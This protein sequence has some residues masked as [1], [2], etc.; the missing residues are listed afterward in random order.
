M[1]SFRLRQVTDHGTAMAAT[2]AKVPDAGKEATR[3]RQNSEKSEEKAV[4]PDFSMFKRT[5]LRKVLIDDRRTKME[6]EFD[7]GK[8]VEQGQ[9]LR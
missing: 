9:E 4:H 2:S 7:A 3:K 1:T 8:S 6:V 5:C